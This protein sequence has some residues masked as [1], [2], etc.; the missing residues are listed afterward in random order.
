VPPCRLR[1]PYAV[2]PWSDFQ[3]VTDRDTG[4]DVKRLVRAHLVTLAIDE[5]HE[6]E[7]HVSMPTGCDTS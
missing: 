7:A 4:F 3:S 6:T 2:G 1:Q 5:L